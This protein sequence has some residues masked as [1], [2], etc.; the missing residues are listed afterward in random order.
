[1]SPVVPV[2]GDEQ[3]PFGLSHFWWERRR[4][5]TSLFDDFPAE[6]M[7]DFML[8]DSQKIPLQ[9]HQPLGD[10][11]PKCGKFHRVYLGCRHALSW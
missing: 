7:Q 8:T 6:P 2:Q 11:S 1:M 10:R 3:K 4:F 5:S 9:L